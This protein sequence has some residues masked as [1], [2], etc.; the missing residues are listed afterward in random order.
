MS[1][2]GVGGA[3][4]LLALPLQNAPGGA[5]SGTSGPQLPKQPQQDFSSPSCPKSHGSQPGHRAGGHQ[6]GSRAGRKPLG[7]TQPRAFSILSPGQICS[8]PERKA[9]EPR[10]DLQRGF[11]K[12][13]QIF[14]VWRKKP[15]P[16]RG[17]GMVL[18]LQVCRRSKSHK[19][20]TGSEG[21]AAG[22]PSTAFMLSLR[23][24][25]VPHRSHLGKLRHGGSGSCE[26]LTDG[27]TRPGTRQRR[28]GR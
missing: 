26:L 12:Q 6:R 27:R 24:R 8:V 15:D 3:Q 23:R 13:K 4:F 17:P 28:G 22:S 16:P 5:Q 21:E 10:M 9:P 25:R 18:A 19:F 1:Q 7:S 11:G 14:A 20:L 2:Q